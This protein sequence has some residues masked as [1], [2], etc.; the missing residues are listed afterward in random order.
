MLLEFGF[1]NFYSF[2]E[3]ASIS[4]RLDANCPESISL[5]KPFATVIGIKGANGSGKTQILK[6]LKFISSFAHQS[7]SQEV[8]A[9]IPIFPFF[10]SAPFETKPDIEILSPILKGLFIFIKP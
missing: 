1:R 4:F 2:R 7:F 10:E 5:G 9:P 3:D 6:A 8:D